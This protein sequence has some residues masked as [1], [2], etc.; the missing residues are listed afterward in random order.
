MKI[1]M[2]NIS[3]PLG[4]RRIWKKS[5]LVTL[6]LKS[7]CHS[8]KW[9]LWATSLSGTQNYFSWKCW[10]SDSWVLQDEYSVTPGSPFP[11]ESSQLLAPFLPER[12][13]SWTSEMQWVHQTGD[14][15][16]HGTLRLGRMAGPQGRVGARRTSTKS[17]QGRAGQK[18]SDKTNFPLKIAHSG[19]GMVIFTHLAGA[20][21]EYRLLSCQLTLSPPLSAKR[22]N[23]QNPGGW[24]SSRFP[25]QGP[26]AQKPLWPQVINQDS[27]GCRGPRAELGPTVG[28]RGRGASWI[29][30]LELPQ[31]CFLLKALKWDI[32]G[33]FIIVSFKKILAEGNF[34]SFMRV[35]EGLN[36]PENGQSSFSL[37]STR[38]IFFKILF[39]ILN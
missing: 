37:D 5:S 31:W 14:L 10:C 6:E 20:P 35:L 7:F 11:L 38:K 12:S 2:K 15:A 30:E 23:H 33:S 29:S 18:N 27:Q 26:W 17:S 21:A 4:K 22:S 8:K 19:K 25:R 24:K 34:I 1:L 32:F 28:S 13:P 3:P 16:V 39:F 9:N 36:F